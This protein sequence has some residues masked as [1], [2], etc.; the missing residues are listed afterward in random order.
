MGYQLGPAAPRSVSPLPQL[1]SQDA[2]DRVEAWRHAVTQTFFPMEVT[3]EQ[4]SDFR[5]SLRT[6]RVGC[7][8]LTRAEADPETVIRTPKLA[9]A[10]DNNHY[11]VAMQVRGACLLTQDDRDV[12]IRPGEFTIYDCSRPFHMRWPTSQ[13]TVVAMFDR[14][15][16]GLTVDQVARVTAT[17]ISGR[18]GI[19]ALMRPILTR[20]SRTPEAFGGPTAARTSTIALDM[21]AA[22]YADRLGTSTG[23]RQTRIALRAQIQAFIKDNLSDPELS[24][25]DIASANF[26]SVRYLHALFDDEELTVGRWVRARRLESIKRDLADPLLARHPVAAIAARRGLLNASYFSQIFRAEYGERPADYRRRTLQ[27]HSGQE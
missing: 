24:V 7:M 13:Q 19:G 4:C 15:D 10:D 6:G 9:A 2:R 16:F 17:R 12:E 20:L 8:Q 18:E 23:A 5:G 3:P 11:A 1:M 25:E 22:L 27:A 14:D 21:L 26:I